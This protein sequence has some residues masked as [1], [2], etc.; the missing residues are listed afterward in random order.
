MKILLLTKK[1][2][3]PLKDGESQ[4][5]HGLSKSLSELGCEVS[6]LA[7][8]TSKHFFSGTKLPEK[9]AH[10]REVRTVGIDNGISP[11]DALGN[12]VRGTSY[13]I[14]RFDQ[15][16][17]HTA[18]TTWLK[19]ETFDVV[20]LETLYLSPYL[21]TIRRHSDAQVVMRSHNVEH[22]IWERCSANISFAPKRWYLRH[23]TRQL[24]SYE[25]AQL[26]QYD[27]L[28]PITAR[29]E[30]RFTTMGFRG[31]SHVLPIGL[32][33]VC[34]EPN[35]E[36]FRNSPDLHFIG[37]LDWMPN[38]EG[39]QWFLNDVWPEVH[40]RF[41]ELKFHVAG[42]NMP[43]YLKQLQMKNVIIHGEVDCSCSFVSAHS[44]SIVP[45]LSGGGMRAK[46]L[47]A[48]SLGRV[49]ISSSIGLEGI[50]AKHRR[51]LFVADTPKQFVE[52]IEDCLSRGR[53][54]ERIG[55]AAATRF[56]KKYDRRVLAERLLQRYHKL[57]DAAIHTE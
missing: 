22:E 30:Q 15:P 35:Y 48:M 4:A 27:L 38:L 2:P 34:G 11:F 26:N 43:E 46:I 9:M 10:Y 20:Q 19:E 3:Y 24:K 1:F 32:D 12:L 17:Y 14:S 40:R 41:P 44:I 55:R 8:N 23:L 56:H 7:M 42:R 54:L 37:S 33:T 36:S 16:A 21:S 57:V 31:D 6:L 25:Q 29:D 52:S 53:K 49:V 39:L 13:H 47:E 50:S 28:L 18:L 5:I 45:L 51:D